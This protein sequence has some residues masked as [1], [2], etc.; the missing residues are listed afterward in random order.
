MERGGSGLDHGDAAG[1][2]WPFDL[3]MLVLLL[4]RL[5]L[6]RLQFLHVLDQKRRG[7]SRKRL[8]QTATKQKRPKIQ[9]VAQQCCASNRARVTF[10]HPA[11]CRPQ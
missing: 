5:L 8:R 1:G 6:Q 11:R 4:R 10:V 7:S 9:P 2:G 3:L